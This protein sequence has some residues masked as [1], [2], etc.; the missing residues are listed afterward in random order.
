MMCGHRNNFN[1]MKCTLLYA[2]NMFH[3]LMGEN[4]SVRH[5][6]F[7][8]ITSATLGCPKG[9]LARPDVD[10]FLVRSQLILTVGKL[11][12][13]RSDSF[14]VRGSCENNVEKV[15]LEFRAGINCIDQMLFRM[16]TVSVSRRTF[17][18]DLMGLE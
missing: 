18:V 3:L 10:N 6:D 16:Y 17:T 12:Q 13:Y 9:K 4:I 11:I 15:A 5:G 1:I 7:T 8:S 14:N 2:A